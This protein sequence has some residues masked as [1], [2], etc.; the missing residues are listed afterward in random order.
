M[1]TISWAFTKSSFCGWKFLP[2][3]WCGWKACWLIRVVFAES[4]DGCGS[5]STEDSEVCHIDW[6]FNK[7]FL[8]STWGSLIAFYPQWNFFQLWS[9]SSQTLPLLSPLSL[10]HVLSPSLSFP[11]SSQR[12]PQE[13]IPSQETTF[14][15]HPHEASPHPFKFDHETQPLVHFWLSFSASFHHIFCDFLHEVLN[16]SE[17]SPRVGVHFFQTSVNVATLTSY[18]DE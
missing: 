4:L 8:C 11:R 9:P 10:C 7:R 13:E 3:C 1:L 2:W 16:P 17:S 12:L 14:F 5:F 6:L 18:L 15:V